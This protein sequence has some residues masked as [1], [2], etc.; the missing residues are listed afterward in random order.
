MVLEKQLSCG[1]HVG[2][3]HTI[4]TSPRTPKLCT[5]L[6]TVSSFPGLRGA[7][8]KYRPWA[9]SK[10]SERDLE[11]LSTAAAGIWAEESPR[12]ACHLSSDKLK[13]APPQPLHQA[14]IAP[15]QLGGYMWVGA[16]SPPFVTLSHFSFPPWISSRFSLSVLNASSLITLHSFI[17]ACKHACIC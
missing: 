7:G 1:S 8:W 5:E 11:L 12:G 15:G 16:C 4:G 3:P 17:H 2:L 9:D 14:L 13:K 6:D 10:L